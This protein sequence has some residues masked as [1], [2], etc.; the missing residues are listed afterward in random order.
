MFAKKSLGQNF[1]HCGW[2]LSTIVGTAQIEQGTTVLEVGPGKGALTERLLEKGASVVAV[3][4]DDRLIPFLQEKFAKEIADK[5]LTIVHGDILEGSLRASLPLRESYLVVANI[6]YYIT[7][8]FIRVMLESQN[9]PKQMVLLLQK[10]VTDRIV[11]T[12]G[13]E[14]LLSLSVKAYGEPKKIK[15]VP[16]DCFNPAPNVD[17]AILAI[18]TISKNFFTDIT[19]E[20]FFELLKAG[21]AQKRKQLAGNLATHYDKSTTE[22]QSVL[23]KIGLI[24]TVRAEEIGV[25]DWKKILQTIQK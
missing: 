13:K 22:I 15:V 5:K 20:K 19:E 18:N 25:G 4:K 6:P 11:A 9:Q 24:K 12:D 7:G 14:S 10:E 21:F 1:L 23:E 3:E 16:A 17:S 2:A 8:Q